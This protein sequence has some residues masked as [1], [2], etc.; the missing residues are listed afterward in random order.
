LKTTTES[1][2]DCDSVK[3]RVARLID[4]AAEMGRI[5]FKGSVKGSFNL[6]DKGCGSMRI[7]LAGY[8]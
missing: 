4:T 5:I 3:D 7:E 2:E 6:A 1:G 8:S